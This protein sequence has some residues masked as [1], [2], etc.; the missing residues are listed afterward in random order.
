[1]SRDLSTESEY[2][3]P[4]PASVYAMAHAARAVTAPSSHAPATAHSAVRTPP[5]PPASDPGSRPATAPAPPVRPAA[6]EEAAPN[7]LARSR[8]HLRVWDV[9]AEAL[10]LYADSLAAPAGGA[11]VVRPPPA[12]PVL[13]PRV[14][15]PGFRM[16][17]RMHNRFLY[18]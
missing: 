2:V 1:M 7:P 10:E 15:C 12:K 14:S 13:P 5:C 4:V 11:G 16:H 6:F 8:S 3:E 17:F 9:P 18:R